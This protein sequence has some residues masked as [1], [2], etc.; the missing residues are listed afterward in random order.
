VRK[1]VQYFPEK[2]FYVLGIIRRRAFFEWEGEDQK[3]INRLVTE[4]EF[5][6]QAWILLLHG[7]NQ[8]LLKVLRH[9]AI[10]PIY[11]R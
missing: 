10:A 2:P 7:V 9:M 3:L 4:L 11:R 6:G 1:V 5:P 8:P